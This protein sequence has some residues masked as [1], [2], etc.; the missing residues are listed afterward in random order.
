MASTPPPL[1]LSPVRFA[2]TLAE[3]T[4]PVVIE[5]ED[6]SITVLEVLGAGKVRLS[7]ADKADPE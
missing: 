6:G 5:S 3:L 1:D 7:R 2:A 4:S